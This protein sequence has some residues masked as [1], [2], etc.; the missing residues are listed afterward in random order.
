MRKNPE[1]LGIFRKLISEKLG[2]NFSEREANQKFLVSIEAFPKKI[3][4][5]EELVSGIKECLSTIGFDLDESSIDRDRDFIWAKMKNKD[6]GF[7]I[8]I[9]NSVTEPVYII[10]TIMR[11]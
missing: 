5:N 2:I 6:E 10:V 11:H 9:T 4:E 3:I 8:G 7:S 1:E